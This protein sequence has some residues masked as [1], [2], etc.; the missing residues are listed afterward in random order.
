MVN[1]ELLLGD[2]AIALGA[3]HAGI[4][5]AYSYPGT[6]STEIFEFIEDRA[7]KFGVAARWS[8]NEKVAYEE[9]LGMSYAGKRALVSMKHV[10]LN[11]AADAFINSAIT[12]VHGG[13]VLC[14]ADDP[15]MHSSQNEQDSRYYAHFA[16]T[17]CLEPANQQEA[18]DMVRQAFD[19][20]EDYAIPV[21]LRLVTRL[22]HSRAAVKVRPGTRQTALGKTRD[23]AAFTLLPGPARVQFAQLAE[24]QSLFRK[25]AE[26]DCANTLNLEPRDRRRGII[27]NGIAMNYV[28]EAFNDAVPHPWLRIG[29]YPLPVAGV[30]ALADAVDEVVVVE[31]GYPFIE[32][33]LRGVYGI[34]GKRIRGRLDGLLPRT[35]ELDP[36]VV[37]RALGVELPVQHR[38]A[39]TP[40][41]KRPPALCPGCAHT[42]SFQAMQEAL[43]AYE[44]GTTFSDIGCYT[45]GFYPPHNAIDSTLDM[46]AS[47]PMAAGAAHAGLHP[48]MCAIGDSTFGHSGLTGLLTAAGEDTNMTVVILDNGTVAMT[49][50]QETLV[51]GE[52]LVK[53]V[54]GLGV[55]PEHIRVIDPLPKDHAV[56]VRVLREEIDHRGLSVVVA[57]RTCIHYR[58]G[59]GPDGEGRHEG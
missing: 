54:E 37:G 29:R 10:G 56:N 45:L 36:T 16:L 49:G 1:Q 28:R 5:G 30:R 53:I 52:R 4:S 42:A 23:R 11:V 17:P 26:D 46:G 22:A 43:S 15:G 20:S 21:V 18:Y 41:P 25:D 48:V 19:M 59:R 9:A 3:L 35:G 32:E 7:E 6:P 31:E 27:A 8:A 14:V 38:P 57:R 51:T 39:I 33:K 40:L 55:P 50:T 44:D 13:V 2:E 58:P 47:I 24:K 34:P 12:G